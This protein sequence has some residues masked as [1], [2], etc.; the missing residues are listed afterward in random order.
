MRTVG[1]TMLTLVCA[2]AASSPATA[3]GRL[4]APRGAC[5]KDTSVHA[6]G[7]AQ[8]RAMRC[9]HGYARRHADRSWLRPSRKLRRGANVKARRIVSCGDF[10]H[11]PC[12]R[13]F[14]DAYR[15]TGYGSGSWSI[16][17]NIAWGSGRL[18]S[19]RKIFHRWLHSSSHR[20][21]VLGR[22]RHIGVGRKR[23]RRLWGERN[24]SVWVTGFG[25]S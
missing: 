4:L 1:L 13:S 17:E 18:G 10:S 22:W 15:R 3:H 7:K 14:S 5:A 16:G 6:G 8:R 25:R 19:A 20:A 11:S 21:N 24:V 12:G 9:L 23:E 2:L